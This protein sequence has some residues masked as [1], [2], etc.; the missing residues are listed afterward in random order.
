[1]V[2]LPFLAISIRCDRD[3]LPSSLLRAILLS[4]GIVELTLDLV[5]A[6]E[7]LL[8]HLLLGESHSLL[9]IFVCLFHLLTQAIVDRRSIRRD[10]LSVRDLLVNRW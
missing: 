7:V 5:D 4:K 10:D 6:F 8:N 1:M 9:V 3:Y 2:N